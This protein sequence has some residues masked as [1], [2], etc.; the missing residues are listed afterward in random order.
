MS[1]APGSDSKPSARRSLW[2]SLGC[3][4]AAIAIVA[5]V[6][7]L[8]LRPYVWPESYLHQID[9]ASK[10][11]VE[12]LDRYTREH[13]APPERLE[14][15][16]PQYLPH[17]PDTGYPPQRQFSYH[18]YHPTLG[19]NWWTL[20]VYTGLPIDFESDARLEFDSQSRQWQRRD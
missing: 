16:I 17:S 8:W 11:V 12:A 5:I 3:A 9:A 18:D 19:G 1:A 10:P 4:L 14:Q 2:A 15:L 20:G 13:G 6:L 7:F